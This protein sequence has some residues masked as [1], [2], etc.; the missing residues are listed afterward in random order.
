MQRIEAEAIAKVASQ[1]V[2]DIRS[3]LSVLNI[4]LKKIST[5]PENER[6]FIRNATERIDDIA[7]NLIHKLNKNMNS[8]KTS[9]SKEIISILVDKIVSEKRV[10]YSNKSIKI[11]ALK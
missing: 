9:I 3:P 5:L 1:V 6:I 11:N 7:N 4:Y 8:C 10:Q 2:H